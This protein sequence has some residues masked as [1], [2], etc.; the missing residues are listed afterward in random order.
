MI[1]DIFD[2]KNDAEQEVYQLIDKKYRKLPRT[3]DGSIN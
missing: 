3:K 2:L 1:T